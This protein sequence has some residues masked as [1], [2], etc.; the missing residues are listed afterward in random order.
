MASARVEVSV[1]GRTLS[2]SNLGKV[3]Y[4]VAGFTK[5]EVIDYYTRIAP[6]LLPHLRDRPLTLKRYPD[7]VDG[8][9]FYEKNCPSHAPDWVR[10]ERVGTIDYWSATTCPRWSGWPTSPT[11]SCT[12]RCRWPT[13][14]S[15][16]P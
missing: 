8:G 1:E 13:T 7:G 9:H 14:S 12:P 2:L 3:L 5:G 4:P 15:V 11:S 10:R 6:A 16:P